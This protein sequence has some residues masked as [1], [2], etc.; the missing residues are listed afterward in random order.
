MSQ[1]IEIAGRRIGQG[2]PP[3]IIAEI[4]INHGGDIELGRD[5]VRLAAEAGA[6][7]AK[8]QAFETSK[9]I[10]RSSPYY[11]IMEGAELTEN[12][13]RDLDAR[14]SELGI[15]LFASV[16]DEGSADLL[17]SLGAPAFKIASGDLTHL[18]LL[19]HVAGFGKP[20]ILSTG[21]AT[22]E[23]VDAAVEAIRS[24]D[25]DAQL[26]ILHCISQY[27][28]Q[29]GDAN[30]ACLATMAERYGVPVGF[31]DHTLGN[32]CA[33][34]AVALGATIIEKHF[35]HDRNADG[36][37][38]QL[39][40]DPAGLKDLVE[41]ARAAQLAVGR[42]KKAPVEDRAFVWQIRR[43]VTSHV[44]I[45]KGTA[46]TREHLAVKRPGTGIQPAQ[47]ESLLGKTAAHDIDADTTLTWNDV[48]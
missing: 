1:Y 37:D 20:I 32:G 44:A 21:G 12:M 5:L 15:T 19:Q 18:P 7:A 11:H 17:N 41:G 16:F 48:E 27:P 42:A 38:H 8:L 25:K 23:E 6:D 36:P 46:I 35:T 31:S 29:P 14:G 30:L 26:A 24:A 28:T 33:I 9:F 34:A 3:Y 47:L 4:G 40:C 10:A 45:P 39:S 43:S 13:T 22:I 2:E